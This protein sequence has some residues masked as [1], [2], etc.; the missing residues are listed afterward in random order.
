[1]LLRTLGVLC[2]LAALG[3]A[4]YYAWTFWGTGLTTSRA[5]KQL[6]AAI[7]HRIEQPSRQ[8]PAGVPA[9][10]AAAVAFRSGDAVALI[11]IP[12]MKLDM[13]VVEGVDPEALKKGPGHYQGTAYPWEDRGR[14][15]IAGHRTTYLHP[16]WSV[17]ELRRGDLIRLETEFGRFDYRVTSS[18]VVLP[19]DTSVLQQTTEP[20]LVLTACTPRFSGSHR[21]VIFASR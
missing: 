10:T 17:N 7:T 12:R 6:R 21:L 5:Q 11:K 4:A 20:T 14:V 1:M 8:R 16:F 13:V 9:T 3:L 2:I 18:R 15:A 19:S